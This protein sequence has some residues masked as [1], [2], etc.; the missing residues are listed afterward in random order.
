MHPYP[1]S[2][3]LIMTHP[4]TIEYVSVETRTPCVSV[5][6]GQVVFTYQTG[7]LDLTTVEV[8]DQVTT[9]DESDLYLNDL[10]HE[11]GCDIAC[12]SS[13]YVHEWNEV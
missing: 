5:I 8:T 6:N 12:I 1:F 2:S 7:T 11:S 10:L 9:Q 13:V 4:R 3:F